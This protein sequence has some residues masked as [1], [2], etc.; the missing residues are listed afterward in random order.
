MSKS[1]RGT[2][3]LTIGELKLKV[4]GV[5]LAAQEVD[6]AVACEFD[7]VVDYTYLPR[8]PESGMGGRF[9]DADWGAPAEC[10]IKAIKADAAVHFEGDNFSCTAMRGTD[11]MPLFSGAQI[12]ELQDKIIDEIERE[13][14]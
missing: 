11:L 9:E 7:V 3:T 13:H 4:M 5:D 6:R 12:T 10:E 1:T 8:I 2:R 14:H